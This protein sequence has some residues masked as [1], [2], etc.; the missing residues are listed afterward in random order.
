MDRVICPRKASSKEDIWVQAFPAHYGISPG[1]FNIDG[2]P[3]DLLVLGG[4]EFYQSKEAIGGDEARK[5]RVIGVL[6]MEECEEVPCK[7]NKDWM[8]DWKMVAVDI[9]DPGAFA[10][11]EDIK[12]LPAE[13]LEALELYFSHYKGDEVIGTKSYPLTRVAG[14]MDK[15]QALKWQSMDFVLQGEE[16]RQ[17]E[18]KQC[19]DYFDEIY[20]KIVKGEIERERDD[21]YLSCLHRVHYEGHL[22]GHKYFPYFLRFAAYQSLFKLKHPGPR[23]EDALEQMENRRKAHRTYYRY[24]HYDHPRP[25]GTGQLIGEWVV[26]KN[27]NKGCPLDFPPQPYDGIPVVPQPLQ[28]SLK[29]L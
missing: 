13:T 14:V 15:A 5:V 21:K 25:E 27:R 3:L 18:V 6:K 8:Q 23:Y 29:A 1:R 24:V 17:R 26:T 4:D 20:P 22:P 16:V 28:S 11:V 19:R 12:Q 9:N 7:K 2:D 10:A